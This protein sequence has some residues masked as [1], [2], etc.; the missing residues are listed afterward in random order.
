MPTGTN[1][2]YFVDLPAVP[3]GYKVTY[4]R[5]VATLYLHKEE[6]NRLRVTVGGDNLD[7][8]GVTATHCASLTTTKCLLNI[9]IYNT[10]SKF[11]VL[12]I[13]IL[14]YNT[15]MDRYEYMHLPLHSIPDEIIA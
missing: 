2:I 5:L 12:K 4:G 13:S 10:R 15:P 9:T 8:P 1:T 6:V 3:C 7:Y 14:Y 11:L